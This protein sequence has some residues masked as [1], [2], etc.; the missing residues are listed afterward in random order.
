MVLA[1]M[2]GIA[3]LSRAGPGHDC[4]GGS[5]CEKRDALPLDTPPHHMDWMPYHSF[6][7]GQTVVAPFGG[8]HALIPRGPFVVVRL[9]P[10]VGDQPQYR[11]RSTVDGHERVVTEQQIKRVETIPNNDEPNRPG[12]VGGRRR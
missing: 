4:L 1:A 5:G 3:R 11:V 7:V 2:A 12:R 10:L 6:K 9:L 8:L